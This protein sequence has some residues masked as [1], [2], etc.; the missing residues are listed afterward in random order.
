MRKISIL[1]GVMMLLTVFGSFILVENTSATTIYVPGTY[2]T[3]K[4][5]IDNATIG[6]TIVVND[7]YYTENIIV[8]KSVTLESANGTSATWINVT[9]N[10]TADDVTIGGVGAGFTI[11]QATVTAGTNAIE[12]ATNSSRNNV[13]I[14]FNYIYGGYD[15][16]HI[17]WGSSDTATN[18]TI[19][20]N[21]IQ[22]TGASAIRAQNSWLK[23]SSIYANQILNTSNIATAGA[24]LLD[25]LCDT[26]IMSNIIQDTKTQGGEGI[27]ITG[28]CNP[29]ELVTIQWN[30]IYDVDGY[31]P[32]IIRSLSDAGYARNTR[33]IS[34]S[35]DNSS[36]AYAEPGIRFDN[37]SG[38]IVATNISVFFNNISSTSRDIEERFALNAVYDNWTGIM[39][40]YFNW[41]GSASAGTF[42][43]ATHLH[44]TPY[45]IAGTAY[46]DITS[47]GTLELE[48]ADTGTF[49][50]TYK[51]DI[52]L[53][54]VTST[55]DLIIVG[56]NYSRSL[57]S[58]YPTRSM[59][60]YV[61]LGVS[62][63]SHITFPVNITIYY[64]ATDLAER[65]WSESK[66]HGMVFYN[67]SCSNWQAFNDTG[68]ST[69]N[70]WGGY[71]GYVWGNAYTASQLTGTILGIDY[72]EIPPEGGTTV[73]TTVDT[74]GDG[75]TDDQEE[76][77]GTNPNIDD[78][79]GDGYTDYEE[80]LAGTNPLLASSM[81]ASTI[82]GYLEQNYIWLIM[83]GILIIFAIILIAI[84]S[85][86]KWK[87][88][89][90]RYF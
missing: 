29:C 67:E 82:I 76:E 47:Y 26:E 24:I 61:E 31:S 44:A 20:S 39:P 62:D 22:N 8:N 81:P 25:G 89:I 33:I 74:D 16:I 9:I 79:D 55:D 34:N 19:E 52:R 78:T 83:L 71:A 35:L 12:I 60:K 4:G 72:V 53:P 50:N 30:V 51:A 15:A 7:G 59:H 28:L 57:L 69:T 48:G 10:I 49:N 88:R 21:V 54:S 43:D 66:I 14:T 27:N 17:G 45:L 46:R 75:L 42:R 37:I 5:A 68:K 87:R 2:S 32:I 56:Y 41:Y 13:N 84:L 80:Y 23:Y 73:P 36:H 63:T 40:A 3:I 11:N 90:G 65:G 1:I 64:T 77:L 70:T 38:N 86:K 6:D 58:T 85:N 18:I